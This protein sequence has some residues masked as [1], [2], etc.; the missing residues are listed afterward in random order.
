MKKITLTLLLLATL[1]GYSQSTKFKETWEFVQANI[2][3]IDSACNVAEVQKTSLSRKRT[4]VKITQASGRMSHTI[5][6]RYRN[7]H[8][9]IKH[10]YRM[11]RNKKIRLLEVDNRV[12]MIDVYWR[13]KGS[14][15]IN[16][17]FTRLGDQ[18]WLW[19][20]EST[21]YDDSGNTR[22]KHVETADNWAK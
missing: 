9:K 18:K 12:M 6:S 1:A 19:S 10:K 16:T 13:P 15:V 21:I 17:F 5:I 20:Y 3:R 2:T 22:E 8:L 11:D 7:C 14:N 4:K